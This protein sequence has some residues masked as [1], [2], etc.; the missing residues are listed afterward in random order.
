MALAFSLGGLHVQAQATKAAVSDLERPIHACEQQVNGWRRQAAVQIVFLVVVVLA[1]VAVS[2]LQKSP[3]QSAKTAIVVLGLTTTALTG[4]NS[5]VF[6]ADDRT[7]RKARSTAATLS[8][9]FG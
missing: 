2:G 7:L 1:G 5:R 6:T 8:A 4:I 3:K 9:S